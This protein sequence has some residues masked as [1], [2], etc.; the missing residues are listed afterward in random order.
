ME[1]LYIINLL[2]ACFATAVLV[3]KRHWILAF[4]AGGSMLVY[5][6]GL[7]H[8]G[9]PSMT[10]L[11][12]MLYCEERYTESKSIAS[13]YGSIASLIMTSIMMALFPWLKRWTLFVW[14]GLFVLIGIIAGAMSPM[15]IAEGSYGICCGI[16]TMLAQ[17]LGLTYLVTCCVENIYIHSLLPTLFAVPAAYIGT[18]I[19]MGG[20]KQRCLAA[21]VAVCHFLL[22]ASIWLIVWNHYIHLSMKAAAQL[23][24][25]ELQALGHFIAP[26]W[27]GY[28]AANILIFVVLFLGDAF[29][30]WVLYRWV[31][32]YEA[33]EASSIK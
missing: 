2:T 15:G 32:H 18:K 33:N 20:G 11:C 7:I 3:W 16:M 12:H 26:G 1:S 31:K 19:I 28:V 21:I 25:D 29:L 8:S 23:C 5:A 17:M 30:S 4:V 14:F 9:T 27:A 13:V 10:E 24:V 6:Y 22:D